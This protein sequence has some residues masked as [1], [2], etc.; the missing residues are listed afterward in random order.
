MSRSS[1]YDLHSGINELFFLKLSSVP[2]YLQLQIIIL[3][4]CWPV[5][6]ILF[7]QHSSI[8]SPFSN[9]PSS[10]MLASLS[11]SFSSSLL[12]QVISSLKSFIFDYVGQCVFFFFHFSSV[13]SHP[14]LQFT[15]LKQCWPVYLIFFQLSSVSSPASDHPPSTMSVSLSPTFSSSP[16]LQVISSFKSFIFHN[17]SQFV[18]FFFSSL[19]CS[20]PSP[21]EFKSPIFDNAGQC[22]S[23]FFLTLLCYKPSPASNHPPSTM[24]AS[25]SHSF[26]QL[27]SV[28]SHLKL[29]ITQ[30]WQCWPACLI[31]FSNSPLFHLQP[32]FTHLRQRWPACLA[33]SPALLCSESS[34]A[35]D[36]SAVPGH[37]GLLP[38][39]DFWIRQVHA[40]VH[41]FE[42]SVYSALHHGWPP[43]AGM[44]LTGASATLAPP[45]T[46]PF[47]GDSTSSSSSSSSSFNREGRWGTTDDFTTSFFPFF[48][49]LHSP[50]GLGELK[51]CPFPGVVFPP[52]QYG[53]NNLNGSSMTGHE[54]S[55]GS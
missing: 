26:F 43:L 13:T 6:L 9:H 22:V 44:I 24:L 20:K 35:W 21:A 39:S 38:R 7:L 12:L 5:C 33:P 27:S 8:S 25:V 46:S 14:Q 2:S 51:V 19:L 3:P 36:H 52:L 53:N 48:P 45:A 28:T 29:Q 31:L 49:V 15:Y 47:R 42:P 16:L 10:T 34:P 1:W 4:Q 41:G 11:H 18:S 40:P 50:L 23:F 32:Q 54:L 17:V 30:L 55:Q 37:G